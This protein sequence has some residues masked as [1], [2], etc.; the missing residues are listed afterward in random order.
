MKAK[1]SGFVAAAC[2]LL[3]SAP[4]QA[5]VLSFGTS[6]EYN[7]GT[8]PSGPPPWM[9]ATFDDDG[10]AG[11][12]TLTLS[13]TNL[14]GS[15]SVEVWLFN[16]DPN[17][18]PDDANEISFSAPTPLSGS[19]TAPVASLG[20]DT[21]KADGDGYFDIKIQFGLGDA[22]DSNQRFGV[23][24]SV[25]YTISGPGLLAGSFNYISAP[26]GGQGEW[27]TAAHVQSTGGGEESGWV[28]IPEPATL[29]LLGAAVPLVLRRK[30]K[31]R[32]HRD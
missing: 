14:T 5:G 8:A 6:M 9:T 18:D 7:G 1:W 21:F 25:Q 3:A 27:P 15:E 12:V 11:S 13:E 19:F 28:T 2:L 4:V 32:R 22:N 24:D 17:V 31:S 23:G 29:L 30:R 26:D 10:S 16:V 20:T